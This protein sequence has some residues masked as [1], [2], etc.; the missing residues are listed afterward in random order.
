MNA[1]TLALTVYSLGAIICY[2]GGIILL[3][4]GQVEGSKMG[5]LFNAIAWPFLLLLMLVLAIP[6]CAWDRELEQMCQD[7]PQKEP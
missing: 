3:G 7:T 4:Q 1:L 2:C 6:C 5:A